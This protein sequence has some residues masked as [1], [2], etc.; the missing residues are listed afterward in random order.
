M[1]TRKYVTQELFSEKIGRLSSQME[2]V[3]AK[4]DKLNMWKVKVVT[5]ATVASAIISALITGGIMICKIFQ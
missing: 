1:S 2:I 5:G 4:V 3:I